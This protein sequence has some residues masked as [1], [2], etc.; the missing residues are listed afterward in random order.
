MKSLFLSLLF[1]GLSLA[2]Q[3]KKPNIVFFFT[4]AFDEALEERLEL[5]EDFELFED[6]EEL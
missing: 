5:F 6:D 4:D 3:A 1:L 2:S